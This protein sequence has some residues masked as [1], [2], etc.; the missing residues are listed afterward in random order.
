MN[1][2]KILSTNFG[3]SKLMNVGHLGPG[4][5]AGGTLAAR[6]V[7][8]AAFLLVAEG[9]FPHQSLVDSDDTMRSVV[10]VNRRFL[11]GPPADDQH[12]DGF[13][14]TNAVAPV[15][16]FFKTEIRL[17]SNGEI[18]T[19]ASHELIC[20]SE[21]GEVWAFN[22]SISSENVSEPES[23]GA[24]EMIVSVFIEVD[25]RPDSA[26]VVVKLIFV[27]RLRVKEKSYGWSVFLIRRANRERLCR[28]IR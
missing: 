3:I 21:G 8:Q 27:E 6:V 7:A 20:S 22:C 2:Y 17:D 18:S 10:V 14:T 25:N 9:C 5:R 4:H 16:S 28:L 19:F 26:E 1:S 11:T 23:G 12:L 15:V 13:V 24:V